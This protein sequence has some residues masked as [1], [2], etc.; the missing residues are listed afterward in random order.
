MQATPA[1]PRREVVIVGGGIAGLAAAWELRDRDVVVFE[2]EERPGGRIRSQR[3]DPYWLNVG[4]FHLVSGPQ[5]P[6][7]H[8]AAEVGVPLLAV[9]GK[10]AVVYLNGRF[11]SGGPVATYPLRVRTPVAARLSFVRTGLRLW[12]ANARVGHYYGAQPQQE[13][14]EL[15]PLLP[16]MGGDVGLDAV[17]L[18]DVLGPMHPD[19]GALFRA[20]TNRLAAEPEEMSGNSGAVMV[21]NVWSG[22]HTNFHL[23]HG[24]TGEVTDAL[25]RQLGERVVTGARVRRVVAGHGA[26]E[27]EVTIGPS[28]QSLSARYVIMATPAY[29]TR[30]LLPHLPEDKA[31]ALEQVRYGPYLAMSILTQET[32]PMPYDD[33][34]IVAC[35]RQSFAMFINIANP[36]RNTPAT[37]QPGGALMLYAGGQQARELMEGTDDEIREAFLRDLHTMFPETRSVVAESWVQRWPHGYPYGQPGRLRLQGALAQ[38][39]ENVF[40]AGDYLGYATMDAAA[41]SGILAARNIRRLLAG[42]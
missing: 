19:V 18:A 35:A 9:P 27:I 7:G 36:L 13:S 37:R 25:A 4:A 11:T 23:V 3:R 34:Y 28:A 41:G 16:S 39:L 1:D 2:A 40:F 22:S 10:A 33:L 24:G 29:I 12:R 6:V 21:G 20:A 15:G 31:H 14:V 42:G 32:G 30:E 8:L 5:S 38:P 26:A 17:T